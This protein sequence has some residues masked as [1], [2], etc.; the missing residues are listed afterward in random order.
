MP[1]RILPIAASA[2]I[3]ASPLLTV[4]D[5]VI[6]PRERQS[7][8]LPTIGELRARERVAAAQTKAAKWSGERITL[9]DALSDATWRRAVV[10]DLRRLFHRYHRSSG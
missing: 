5:D 2:M 4:A 10:R 1:K 6:T 7:V 9:A 8:E 3:F